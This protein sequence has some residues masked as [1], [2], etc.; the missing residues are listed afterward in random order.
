MA[1]DDTTSEAPA[2]WRLAPGAVLAWAAAAIALG[3]PELASGLAIGLALASAA[4]LA[5]ALVAGTRE[6][7]ASRGL[8]PSSGAK[9]LAFSG[10]ASVSFAAAALVAC[11][12][13]VWLEART[14]PALGEALGAGPRAAELVVVGLLDD[15]VL[16]ER[17]DADSG[18]SGPPSFGT[19][20][21]A[22]LVA[23][24][25][26]DGVLRELEAP[27]LVSGSIAADAPPGP[28]DRI[29]GQL[30]L[31]PA[32]P[33][34]RVAAFA[35]LSGAA[36]VIATADGP[37]GATASLRAGFLELSAGLPGA[38]GELL[39]GLA[40]GDDRRV[41]EGLEQAMND[42]SL[43]HL[44]AVSGANCALVVG[45]V[46]LG[47]R[48][49]GLRRGVRLAF[50]GL[51][52]AAFVALVTPQGS[53]IRASAM[54]GIVLLVEGAGR[55]VSGPPVLCLA[56]I[57]LL[58]ADPG[59]ALDLGFA[60]SAAATLGLLVGAGPLARRLEGWMPRPLALAIAVPV[61]AQLA[62]QPVL[63]LLDPAL[64]LY[65]VLANLLAAP[66][67]PIA[68]VAGL[69]ACLLVGVAPPLALATAW[70]AWLPAAWIGAVAEVC[71]GWPMARIPWPEGPVGALLLAAP[72]I[73]LFALLPDGGPAARARSRILAV[74]VALSAVLATGL[75]AG[76][77]VGVALGRPD[78]WRYAA[79]DVGQGD[80]LV[81]RTSSGDVLVDTGPEPADVLACLRDLG[82]GRLALLVLTHFD[83][84]HSGSALE[85]LNRADALLVPDTEEAR[86][87]RISAIAV[88]NGIPVGFGAFGDR[89]EMGDLALEILWPPRRSDGGPALEGGN[90]ESLALLARPTASCESACLS[91]A[92]LA[93]LDADA[94]SQLLRRID[95][96]ARLAAHVVKVSHHGSRDQAPELYAAIR[97]RLALISVGATNGYG[98]P[99]QDALDLLAAVHAHPARTDELGT[100]LVGGEADA[101]RLA[102][103]E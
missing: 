103:A 46:L 64:P 98:H 91:L 9:L 24:A 86:G 74:G 20:F 8:R 63:V 49:V 89:L 31:R 40:V 68:T 51:A 61:A 34:E 19:R 87:E 5:A 71:A 39:P 52:L 53:V 16:A 22:V 54:A 78:P 67:A 28:G 27:V 59:L 30:R 75:L 21:R 29:A 79:C 43:T 99:T 77:A 48:A 2:D 13:L 102:P 80:A 47:G 38:G 73:A 26:P 25:G 11:S 42:S 83:H 14:P 70:I 84:D 60:L 85:L 33:S 88:G 69:V 81:L 6:I 15:A 50:A 18:R 32:P 101:I 12:A 65:G 82:V 37:L 92:A 95:D 4:A 93:D 94:Q 62:C 100:I 66:A 97:P 41:G 3:A 17:D 7:R 45:L 58:A 57:A 72:T 36:T 1:D 76:R 44:T 23:L 10:L 90:P 35:R 96:P 55:R 56:V